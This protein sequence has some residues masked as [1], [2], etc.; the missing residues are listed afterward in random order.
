MEY[1]KQQKGFEMA[2]KVFIIYLLLIK[3][4]SDIAVTAL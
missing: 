3:E 1:S 4:S 2:D